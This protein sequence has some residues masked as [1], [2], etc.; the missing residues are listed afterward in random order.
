MTK[1]L[2]TVL[3]ALALLLPCL[4]LPAAA[5]GNEITVYNWGQYISDGTDGYL[6][7]I[8]AFEAETGIKVHYMTYDSNESLYTRLKT[9]GSTYDVIIPSD[10]MIGRLIAEDMLEELNF[11]NIPNYQYVDESFRNQAYDPENR[12]SVPYTWGTVGVIYN[13]KYVDEEDVG[14]WDLLWNSK[15][16]GKTLMFDNCRDAFAIAESMLGYSMNSNDAGELRNCA[17]LLAELKPLVQGWVMDQIYGKMEREEAWIAPYYA[18][19]YLMMVEENPDLAFY[20]PEEGFNVFI[21][22]ACIPKG[23]SNK[24]GA[25]A[26]INF[27]CRPDISGEN[28]EYLGYSTP[29]SAAKEYMDEEVSS[30]PIAYP[31]AETLAR[32]ESFSALDTETNQ[33]MD[34]LWLSVKTSG[35]D[36]TRYWISGAVL[37]GAAIALTVFLKLRRRRRLARRGISR[38][39]PNPEA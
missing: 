11:D 22:A 1:R 26:F 10:Y 32:S 14:G 17:N 18:G 7:V 13:T 28:L 2:F 3:L 29:L 31:D 24:E 20:F 25:E 34:S 35:S 9:G 39:N 21:D 33:L 5:A 37:L 19:D 4:A 6:D 16:A 36:T 27:L 38:R 23:C 12:Y 8:A 15:Y 30:S